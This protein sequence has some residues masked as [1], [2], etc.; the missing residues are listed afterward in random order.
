MKHGAHMNDIPP[1]SYHSMLFYLDA[2]ILSKWSSR[3]STLTRQGRMASETI[4]LDSRLRLQLLFHVIIP[5]V[6][7]YIRWYYILSSNIQWRNRQIRS[8]WRVTAAAVP[9]P[10]M[11]PQRLVSV[12]LQIT[13]FFRNKQM[14]RNCCIFRAVTENSFRCDLG[15]ITPSTCNCC[16]YRRSFIGR[17]FLRFTSLHVSA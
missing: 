9:S 16:L 4:I 5:I 1:S 8:W 2:L 13:V 17:H 6:V 3:I 10:R 12:M 14:L 15:V 7:F 11:V